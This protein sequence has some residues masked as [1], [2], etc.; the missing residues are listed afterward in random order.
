MLMKFWEGAPVCLWVTLASFLLYPGQPLLILGVL[1]T[2]CLPRT[3]ASVVNGAMGTVQIICHQSGG[4][5]SLPLAVMLRF[6][7]YWCPTL[8]DGSVPIVPQQR[9]WI[10]GGSACSRLQIPLSLL[11]QS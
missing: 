2:N 11:G 3:D 10:Q 5:P 6:D 8:R 7:K 1:H 4:P 9:T